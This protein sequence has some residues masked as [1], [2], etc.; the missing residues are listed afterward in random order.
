MPTKEQTAM[1]MASRSTEHTPKSPNDDE[2]RDVIPVNDVPAFGVQF[3]F[4]K[5]V[6]QEW[7]AERRRRNGDEHSTKAA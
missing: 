1:T 3:R 5:R 6:F 2:Q 7:L 4:T